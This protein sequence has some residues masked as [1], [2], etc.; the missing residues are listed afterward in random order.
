MRAHAAVTLGLVVLWAA[1]FAQ[2]RHHDFVDWDDGIVIVENES[3]QRPLD[4]ASLA[5]HFS[6]P[7]QGNW[8]PLALISLHVDH[9]LH[10]LDPSGFHT[11][12]LVLH[13]LTTLLLYALLFRMTAAPGPSA[14]VAAVFAVHPLH[15][16]S[17]VWAA[18]RKDV[19][20]G[21]LFVATL[22]AYVAWTRRPSTARYV[23]VMAA[24]VL[25]LMSKSMLVTLPF[26]LLLLDL[27]PLGRLQA[28]PGAPL[29]PDRL[30]RA[31]LEKLPLL[32]PVAAVSWIT[33]ALQHAHGS[34]GFAQTL[35]L[36]Q[37]VPNA[38]TSTVA[39]L[40]DSFWPTGLAVFYPHPRT[41]FDSRAAAAAVA[42]VAITALVLRVWRARPYLPVGWLW[43]LGMLLPVIGLVQVGEQARA[44][45]Y[46]Y[47][48]QIGL[49]LMVAWGVPALA[50]RLRAPPAV[51]ATLAV[52]AV[53]ALAA[54]AHRQVATWADSVALFS[55][56]I[57][58]TRDNHE[59]HYRL[60]VA[61]DG[62]GRH[63]AAAEQFREVLRLSP[64]WA[65]A[66]YS[67]AHALRARGDCEAAAP[68][69]DRA[70]AL[71]PEHGLA[72]LERT[73]CLVALGRY[74]DAGF[75]LSRTL[76]THPERADLQLAAARIL[77]ARGDARGALEHARQA[78]LLDPELQA[79]AREVSWILAASPIAALR[80][81]EEAVAVARAA[82]RSGESAAGL[83]AL[84]VALASV[85]RFGEAIRT[86]ERAA[87]LA[88]DAGD[89]ARAEAIR[90]R[91][92][93]FR[94][95]RAHVG[96]APG[97]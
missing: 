49:C 19:L 36:G 82:L 60:G 8:I 69:Y 51:P 68:H 92:A 9:A 57:A 62:A 40:A 77:A 34:M 42:L 46:T 94:V 55:R 14:F 33:F 61:L 38:L 43:F 84:A 22:H 75:Q 5:Y 13:L 20:S 65:I 90:T 25:G 2:A 85:G 86:G 37:R 18:E 58:V 91:V 79:A 53:L 67:L 81:P 78:L 10:G 93:G 41:P 95:G 45:R 7:I 71:D 26:V 50:R 31:V 11:T 15:V 30:R 74:A 63:E 97:D 72:H 73:L 21:L 54:V 16:E 80:R 56:A 88:D 52:V 76:A 59:A 39:Y 27:W 64:D 70:I 12:N 4:A 89:P 17:V 35:P 1:V 66:S 6:H 47:L 29:A 28:E 44:D 23:G 3:I 24:L 96:P 48:P 32:V 83:D 87:A